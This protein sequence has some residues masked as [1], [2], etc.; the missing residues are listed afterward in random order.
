MEERGE[1][2][3]R[4][5]VTKRRRK[6]KGMIWGRGPGAVLVTPL[7]MGPVYLPTYLARAGLKIQSA[8][9]NW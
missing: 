2:R 4:D 6:K 3:E 8:P 5:R 7:L 9:A 1:K